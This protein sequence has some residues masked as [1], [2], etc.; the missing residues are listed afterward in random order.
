MK[1]DKFLH[2]A[3]LVSSLE[4]SREFYEGVLGLE[5]KKRHSFN[6]QGA[7]YDLGDCELHLIVTSEPLPSEEQ[8]PQR[9]AHVSFLINDYEEWKSYLNSQG[10]HTREGRSGLK[11]LFIRD[12]DGN[13]VE[14]QEREK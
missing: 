8:R 14:L 9:D 13:L 11:Q 3:L 7:W 2:A 1:V 6:F 12:P 10:I 4:R 5:Q